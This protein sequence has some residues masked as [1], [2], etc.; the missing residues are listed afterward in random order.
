MVDEDDKL[1]AEGGEG[2]LPPEAIEAPPAEG[3]PQPDPIEAIAK[4][5]GWTPKEEFKGDPEK[6]KPA[7]QFIRDG[8][9][10]QRETATRLRNV[11]ETMQRMSSTSEALYQQQ[12]ARQREELLAQKDEAI[13]AGD[14]DAVRAIDQRLNGTGQQQQPP[15]PEISD[16][17]GRN[18]W[19]GPAGHFAATQLAIA[20]ADGEAR[21]G[22]GPGMQAKAAEDE[23]RRRYPELFASSTTAAPAKPPPSV[24]APARGAG[25]SNGKKGYADMPT[26][27]QQAAKDFEENHGIPKETYA[28]K[29][30][31]DQEKAA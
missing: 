31:Q 18:N 17:M 21:K 19:F 9:E 27:A 13:E 2:E 14:K 7:D 28:A 20:I 24:N 5:I 4:E 10:I 8:R 16:F 11:E 15:P 23:V 12:L 30:W 26:A 25:K 1:P 6:W 29:F 22:N 3:D